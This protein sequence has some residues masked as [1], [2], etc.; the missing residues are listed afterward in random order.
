[1]GLVP[2][3]PSLLLV[4]A[5]SGDVFVAVMPTSPFSSAMLV[6]HWQMPKWFDP[7]AVTQPTPEDSALEMAKSMLKCAA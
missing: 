2:N 4:G 7:L 1:M 6:Y 5:T 3:T